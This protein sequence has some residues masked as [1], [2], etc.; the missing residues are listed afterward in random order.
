VRTCGNFNLKIF[1]FKILHRQ[2]ASHPRSGSI[3]SHFLRSPR[4][5]EFTLENFTGCTKVLGLT[6][7]LI[8]RRF[9]LT[10]KKKS[11]QQKINSRQVAR[12]AVFPPPKDDA[13]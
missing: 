11:S 7:P 10:F 3:P 6:A 5:Q 12:L 13:E 9:V 2:L 1:L 8:P 4:F